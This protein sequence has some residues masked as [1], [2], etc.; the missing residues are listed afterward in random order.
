MV[1]CEQESQSQEEEEIPL[2]EGFQWE[3]LMDVSAQG[4]SRKR[5]L[6]ESSFAPAST[7]SPLA[8]LTSEETVQREPLSSEQLRTSDSPSS[9]S[10]PDKKDRQCQPESKVQ[11][12]PEKLTSTAMKV[13]QRSDSA[14]GDSSSE[15][16]QNDGQGTGKRRRAAKVSLRNEFS[17]SF[18]ETF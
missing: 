4:T 1:P 18:L 17:L 12:H 13:F 11:K 7:H 14:L 5:S 15:T 8:S 2:L 9:L 10:A 16:E 6:S 3:S